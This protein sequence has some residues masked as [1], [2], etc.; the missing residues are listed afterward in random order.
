MI[1]RA[2]Q[3]G[4]LTLPISSLEPWAKFNGITFSGIK[5]DPIPG[6]G[7]GVVANCDLNGAIEEGGGEGPLMTIPKELV[8]SLERVRMFALADRDLSEVLEAMGEFCRV[9]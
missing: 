1:R 8:L 9:S 3:L 6:S 5:C 4:H 2:R 7:S